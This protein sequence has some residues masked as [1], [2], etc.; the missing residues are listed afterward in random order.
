MIPGTLTSSETTTISK[1]CGNGYIDSYVWTFTDPSGGKHTFPGGTD[2]SVVYVKV[3]GSCTAVHNTTTVTEWSSDL[4]YYLQATGSS[5]TVTAASGYINPRYV[6]LGVT[7]APPGNQSYV[8]YADSTTQGTSTSLNGSFSTKVGYTVSVSSTIG[9]GGKVAGNIGGTWGVSDTQTDTFSEN[10]TQ[11]Q[12]T[13]SSVALS[14]TETWTNKIPGP[15]SPYVGVDHDYDLIWLWLNPLLNF[16]I[17]S[18]TPNVTWTGYDFDRDDIAEMDIYPVYLGFLLGHL[19][20]PGPNSQELTP[21]ER[22][23]AASNGQDWPAG[24]TASLLNATDTAFNSTDAA[25][26]AAADPFS[27]PNYTVT[28]PNTPTGNETSSDGRFTLTGNQV[29]DYV[30]PPPGGQPFTQTLTESTTNTQTQG[31]GAKYTLEIGYSWENM[32]KASFVFD[33]ISES[34][35]NSDT[36]TWTDQWSKTNTEQTGVTA[37]GSVTGPPCVVSVT[38]CNPV[39]TGPTEYEVFQ[40]NIYN[41]FMFYPVN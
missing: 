32:F 24:I 39:Y 31:E 18:G 14:S 25:A 34:V 17:H 9:A 3:L 8:Q 40:D 33:S 19:S 7:Y 15:L 22:T 23:W 26:I 27:N 16:T 36:L 20:V 4:L 30:Q 13:S 5:G 1:T 35:T 38:S 41:T 11:E 28:V 21:F 29:V 37:T 2:V 10:Y 12:D 6:I